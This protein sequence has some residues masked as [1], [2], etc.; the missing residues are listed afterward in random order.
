MFFIYCVL[1]ACSI[2][3]TFQN[4]FVWDEKAVLKRQQ[5]EIEQG[6]CF[7]RKERDEDEDGDSYIRAMFV[8]K[9]CPF[10][11][12]GKLRIIRET[13]RRV[14]SSEECE[15]PQNQWRSKF[16]KKEFLSTKL[17]FQISS[18]GYLALFLVTY[19]LNSKLEK[20]EKL[21][22]YY[23]I[24]DDDMDENDIEDNPKEE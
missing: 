17:I 2:V 3:F 5:V 20:E 14:D 18:L 21:K 24:E 9:D 22:D 16:L 8:F 19:W 12:K 23:D 7:V 11:Q 13:C 6:G 4:D 15:I 10:V 1:F